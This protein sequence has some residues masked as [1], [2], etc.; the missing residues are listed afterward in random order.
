MIEALKRVAS[1][2]ELKARIIFTILMLIVC[3]IGVF[4]PVPGIHG[5]LALAYFKQA[6]GGG[7][8]L[9]QLV[10]IFSGG[11]FAQMTVIALGVVPYISASIIMQL[12]MALMPSMQRELREN[13]DAGKRKINKNTRLLTVLL[14]VIQSSMFA[15]YAIQMN[16]ANPGIILPEMLHIQLFGAP[17]LFYLVTIFTM[18]TGTIFLMWVGEQI[19]ENGIG[20]GMSLIICLGILSSLPTT[21]GTLFT[22]LNLDSQEAGQLNFS[23]LLVLFAV[24][25]LVIVATILI[26]QGV[27]KIPV[28][29]ARR[30]V[31][32]REMQGGGSFIPLKINYAGVIPVIF[33]SS[34]LMFPAT[35][36]QFLGR[37]GFLSRVAMSLSPGS[38]VYMILYVLMI[39]FFTYFWTATQFHP[40]QIAS[41]MKRNGAFIPGIR[42]GKPTQDYLEST[43]NRVTLIGA[44]F[45]ALIAILPSLVGKILHVDPAI[46]YFFGGTA[47]LILVGVVLDTMKQIESHLLMK[48]YDGF[49]KK[50]KI[51]G[52]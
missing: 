45:L 19:T 49:M 3:R 42:Q 15:R 29:H 16:F 44:V 5:E 18:T 30:V 46:S 43:M 37:G 35:I 10:D 41:D 2:P 24:F 4:I 6:T 32:R 7:Q 12:L 40:E 21:I 22:Q 47:L 33:A 26:I 36:A 34:L 9:F 39:L 17:W 52:R 11:A 25:C 48:R 13:P 31:G 1:I 14:A 27:R 28:Q 8:N 51:R 20:N 23:S 50:G 38:M